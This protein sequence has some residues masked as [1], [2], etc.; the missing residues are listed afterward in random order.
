MKTSKFN[1]LSRSEKDPSK[2]LLYNTLHDHRIV[3]DASEVNPKVFFQKIE[4][5]LPLNAEEIQWSHELKEIGVLLEDD[6]DEQK[7]F[8]DWYHEK[9][10]ERSD[11]MQVTILPLM[12]CNLACHYCFENEVR[13]KGKM[14]SETTEQLI[15]WMTQK[16]ER[17]RPE[18]LHISFFGGEPLLH[19]TPIHRISQEMFKRCQSLGIQMEMGMITNGVLL[20]PELVDSLIPYG[21]K[22]VKITFDGDKEAH[23]HKRVFHGGKGTF[24]IIYDNLSKIHGKLK[25]A[26]GGNFDEENYASMYSLVERLKQS[27]FGEDIFIARFKPIMPMNTDVARQREGGKISSMCEGCSY[28][29]HQIDQIIQ[30]EKKVDAVGF[31]GSDRPDLGP[32]EFHLRH[33]VTVGPDGNLYKCPA[34][35]GLKNLQAGHVT[36]IDLNEEGERQ[37]RMKKWAKKCEGCNFLPNCSGGCRMSTFNRT[38]NLDSITCDGAFLERAT[39]KF[40]QEELE[41]LIS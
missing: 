24:D 34:F 27:P 10:R 5:Q 17:V 39:E 33:S 30:L 2:F 28:S 26:I 6:Q 3:F 12:G 21:F 9:I 18:R 11:L 20:T 4:E 40:M 8:E 19:P 31:H 32:C 29:S 41:K 25:I 35:V 15:S 1:I 13:E 22:W 14:S 16:I 23:D 36:S 38:G 7:I 37:V